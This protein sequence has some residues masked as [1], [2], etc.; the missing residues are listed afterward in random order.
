MIA[1]N[2]VGLLSFAYPVHEL[3]HHFHVALGPVSFAELPDIDDVAVENDRFWVDAAEI[4]QKLFGMAAVSA[5]MD[6]RKNQHVDLSSL[7]FLK[8]AVRDRIF[9]IQRL[10][11]HM[12]SILTEYEL[13]VKL[14]NLRHLKERL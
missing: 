1:G 8:L 6:I 14:L 2:I 13:Y 11:S 9:H 12:N 3:L 5:E 10:T 4:M 7:A